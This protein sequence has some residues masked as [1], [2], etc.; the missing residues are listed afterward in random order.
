MAEVTQRPTGNRLFSLHETLKT[1]KICTAVLGL[2]GAESV[3]FTIASMGLWVGLGWKGL[4]I[5]GCFRYW[6]D[7]ACLPQ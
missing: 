7:G 4:M 6:S 3:F 1:S 5:Q 2:A